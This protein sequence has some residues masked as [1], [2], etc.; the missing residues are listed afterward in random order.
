MKGMKRLYTLDFEF[1]HKIV[2]VKIQMPL[3]ELMKI[4]SQKVR[5][6]IESKI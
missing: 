5:L 4:P 2:K 6:K 3:M 1:S